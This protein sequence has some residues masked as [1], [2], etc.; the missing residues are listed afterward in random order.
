MAGHFPITLTPHNNVDTLSRRPIPP[1]RR[2]GPK[3]W[4][5]VPL[6]DASGWE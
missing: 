5:V 6:A 2:I 4:L 1:R 3:S